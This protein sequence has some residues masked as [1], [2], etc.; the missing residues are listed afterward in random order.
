MS[1]TQSSHQEQVSDPK[2]V[3]RASAAGFVGSLVE[4]YDYYIYGT[5]SALIFSHQFFSSASSTTGLLASFATFGVGFLARPVGGIVAGH[6]GDRIGRKTMLMITLVMMGAATVGIGLLPSYDQVGILA[7]ILLV[8][9]RLLQ[10]FAVGGEWGGAV[11]LVVEHAP[12]KRRGFFGGLP[13]AGNAGGLV[14]AT[15]IFSLVTR[16]PD[17]QLQ[18]WGWRIP[19]LLSVVLIVVGVWIRRHIEDGQ[20]FKEAAAESDTKNDQLPLVATFRGYWRTILLAFGSAGTVFS[21]SSVAHTF[22]VSYAT[23][24]VGMDSPT[25]LTGVMFSALTAFFCWPASGWL[26]DKV[27]RKPVMLT[28]SILMLGLSFPFFNMLDTGKVGLAWFAI[29]ALYGVSVGLI[30]GVLPSFF[31]ELFDT[32]VRYTGVSIA[33]QAPAVIIGGFTPFIATWLVS[34]S[35]GDSWTVSLFLAIIAAV[36]VICL[37]LTKETRGASLQRITPKG[38]ATNR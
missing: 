9:L 36:S 28:G 7:P 8:I 38:T 32:S 27:G 30:A 2:S 33:Y 26:S 12:T 3:W 10:G 18:S 20:A 14:L 37:I 23:T 4:W 24:E 6:F 13:Q 15:G 34:I 1:E 11:V 21:C 16:L 5:A 29:I 22:S 19:F 17:E 31:A 25:I 35:D